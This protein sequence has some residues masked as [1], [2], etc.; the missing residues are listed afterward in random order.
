M[1]DPITLGISV[2]I[3]IAFF[4]IMACIFGVES[5]DSYW[6]RQYNN[7]PP[8]SQQKLQWEEIR[9]QE[10]KDREQRGLPKLNY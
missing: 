4:I 2:I 6:K 9:R 3:V 10:N 5:S 7:L 8:E 1:D